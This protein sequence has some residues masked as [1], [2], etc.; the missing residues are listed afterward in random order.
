MEDARQ[1]NLRRF[2]SR[3]GL[4]VRAMVSVNVVACAARHYALEWI[5]GG[6]LLAYWV[7]VLI[8]PCRVMLLTDTKLFVR[9]DWLHRLHIARHLVE[10]VSPSSNGVIISCRKAGV[11]HYV[12]LPAR[13]FEEEVWVKS[14]PALL[15]WVKP[16]AAHVR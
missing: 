6:A 10:E 14:Y 8:R 7:W 5:L 12:E 15:A 3:Q 11:A 16:P 2:P 13:W 9:G 4:A 1:F